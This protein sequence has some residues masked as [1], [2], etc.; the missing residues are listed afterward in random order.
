MDRLG[1]A[2]GSGGARGYA[3][4]G[5]L[6][7]LKEEGF[8]PDLITGSSIGALIGVL[9]SYYQSAEKVEEIILA[10]Y[11][12]DALEMTG[13]SRGGVLS[14]EKV[15]TFFSKF[16]GDTYL[17]DLSTPVGVVTTDFHTAKP[18]LI[19]KG[20]AVKAM[21]A[22]AA[23]P[24]FIEPLEIDDR[25][26]WDGGLSSQVPTK[27]ARQMGATRVIG[28]N[29]NSQFGNS[30][31]YNGFNPYAIGRRAIESLQYHMTEVDM[32]EVDVN[33][34]P[35]LGSTKFLGIGTLVKKDEG[36]EIIRKG[37]DEAKKVIKE[38]KDE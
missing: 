15:Q 10:S 2:L 8:E 28:V 37:Y 11:W 13:I 38:I 18:V 3:H 9:Y 27:A 7:A 1:L 23:F 20:S 24:L 36:R 21:Q 34:S 31:E 16:V 6:K 32:Q 26:F 19:K 14:A 12:R 25:V 17:E 22:S 4:I 35:D 33:I 29:L 5:A 30:E